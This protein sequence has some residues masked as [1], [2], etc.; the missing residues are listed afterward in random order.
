MPVSWCVYVD[1]NGD[2]QLLFGDVNGNVYQWNTGTGDNQT[3]YDDSIVFLFSVIT[4]TNIRIYGNYAS[5]ITI[6]IYYLIYGTG[7][8][9]MV[10]KNGQEIAVIEK[11]SN[12]LAETNPDNFNFHSDY[13]TL[14][15]D[16]SGSYS[17]TVSSETIYTIPHNLGYIPFFIGFVNDT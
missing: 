8:S 7:V 3:S 10:S 1:N 17:M 15:Y 4:G 6:S 2:E 13:P 16:T 12:V 11:G 14:K 9:G 5:N